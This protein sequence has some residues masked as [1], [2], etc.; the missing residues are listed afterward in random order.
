MEKQLIEIGYDEFGVVIAKKYLQKGKEIIEG[1]RNV[2]RW[3]KAE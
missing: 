1:D 2:W 3:E